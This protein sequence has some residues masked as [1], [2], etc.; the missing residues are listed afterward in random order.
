MDVTNDG[1][2]TLRNFVQ[3]E[4]LDRSLVL[5]RIQ[6]NVSSYHL[7][8]N[9]A[10]RR[11]LTLE[12]VSPTITFVQRD[13]KTI[14]SFQGHIT[15]ASSTIA[16]IVSKS[17]MSSK[18]AFEASGLPVP[19]GRSFKAE[20]YEEGLQFFGESSKPVVLKPSAGIMGLGISTSVT[21]DDEFSLAWDRAVQSKRGNVLVEQQCDGL[22]VRAFVVGGD[23]V[24]AIS[25]IPSFVVGNGY[26]T[27]DSLVEART[28]DRQVNSYLAAMTIHVDGNVLA[29]QGHSRQSIP[30]KD[31]IVFLNKTG[32]TSQGAYSLDVTESISEG[33]RN[34]AVA[35][36]AAIPNLNVAGIDLIVPSLGD[37]EGAVI[38]ESNVDAAL[39]LHRY[40]SFG[41]PR[42]LAPKILDFL[43]SQSYADI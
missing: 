37:T 6:E 27:I 3:S 33:V 15:S 36:V 38:L 41:E 40:P 24:A 35:A 1:F 43:E 34:L 18:K 12:K 31:E 16:N 29:I 17:K 21:N 42:F 14:G 10:R 22:D 9:E 20:E 4:I 26:F 11:E 23:V 25:R 13:G 5:N 7:L 39:Q 30:A 28:T 19:F 8:I 32:N 2:T